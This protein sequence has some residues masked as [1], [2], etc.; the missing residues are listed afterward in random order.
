[1]ATTPRA[2]LRLTPT[3]TDAEFNSVFEQAGGRRPDETD[4]DGGWTWKDLLSSLEDGE[5][6]EVVQ[7]PLEEVLSAEIGAMGID[8]TALLPR[9][10]IQDV[11]AALQARDG[12]QAR[13]IVRRLAPA[14]SRRLARKLFTDE[15]LKRQVHG[16]LHRYQGL[17]EEAVERDPGGLLAETLLNSEAGRTYLLFDAA[18]GDLA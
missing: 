11:T 16:Y 18:V 4:A 10:R 15:A 12:D 7:R 2:R 14:A 9:S 17:I 13:Q 1:M 3:A 5:E 8:P 6:A